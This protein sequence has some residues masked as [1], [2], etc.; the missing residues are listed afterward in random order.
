MTSYDLILEQFKTDFNFVLETIEQTDIIEYMVLEAAG[1]LSS[2]QDV[3]LKCIYMPGNVSNFL[4]EDKAPRSIIELGIRDLARPSV[5]EIATD[6]NVRDEFIQTVR[7]IE[8]KFNGSTNN[9][10]LQYYN[11]NNTLY[12][13]ILLDEEID[14][15]IKNSSLFAA[16]GDISQMNLFDLLMLQKKINLYKNADLQINAIVDKLNLKIQSSISMFKAEDIKKAT[17]LV[18]K[19]FHLQLAINKH[20]LH[21]NDLFES[22][23]HTTNRLYE[24]ARYNSEYKPVSEVAQTLYQTIAKARKDFFSS[25]SKEACT[26]FEKRCSEAIE[27]A[28]IEFSKFRGDFAWY[29]DLHPILQGILNFCKAIMGILSACL[30]LPVLYTEKECEQGFY[31]TFFQTKTNSLYQLERFQDKLLGKEGIMD[32]MNETLSLR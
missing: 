1:L 12:S 17:E 19:D 7:M 16:A 5:G 23:G 24:D 4:F 3:T 25:P 14:K 27:T 10:N 32:Q 18:S 26:L 9:W 29:N 28:K 2:L 8:T 11:L 6:Q 13:V 31:G 22:L 20:E 21:F 15:A 30:V